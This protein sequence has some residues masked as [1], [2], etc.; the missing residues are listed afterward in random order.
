MA[1]VKKVLQRIYEFDLTDC[2]LEDG[3]EMITT[4][5]G[6]N[7]FVN[8]FIKRDL[9]KGI[10]VTPSGYSKGLVY[11]STNHGEFYNKPE[12]MPDV[13]TFSMNIF[14]LKKGAFYRLTVIGRNTHKYNKLIDVTDDRSLEVSNDNQELLINSDLSDAYENTSYSGVFRAISNEANLFFRIGKV[15]VNNIIIDEIEL[16]DTSTAES[17]QELNPNEQAAIIEDG[18][19]KIVAYGIFN[20]IPSIE[21]PDMY[22]GRYLEMSKLTGKGINLYYDKV[23]KEY[24]IERDNT[25]DTIS[26]SL[27]GI[28][29]LINFNFNK[30]V[31]NGLFSGYRITEVSPDISP[32]TLKQGYIKFIFVDKDEKPVEYE[33]KEGRLAFTIEKIL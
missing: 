15:Y 16:L 17:Q 23:T 19:A 8:A 30:V 28:E 4:S 21:N 26:G 6:K 24:L 31:N 10:M 29:Y 2:D 33:N 25:E 18:H 22:K 9:D 20:T 7:E 1:D 5:N 11:K 12:W 27:T 3:N 13:V 32:N 14:G